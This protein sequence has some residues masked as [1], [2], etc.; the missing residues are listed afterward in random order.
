MTAAQALAEQGRR[1]AFNV[2]Y[3]TYTDTDTLSFYFAK[4]SPGVIDYSDE[5]APGVA[6]DYSA[7]GQLVSVDL[8][9]ASRTTP[10]HLFDTAEPVGGKQPL[11]I[12]WEYDA[13]KDELSVV[14]TAT[15]ALSQMLGTDDARINIGT[16]DSGLWQSL[17]IMQASKFVYLHNEQL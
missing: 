15:K 16:C 1:C 5:V 7:S 8:N 13:T 14:L 9:R 12:N 17:H 2:Q 4:A 3:R 6:V 10:C 11:G